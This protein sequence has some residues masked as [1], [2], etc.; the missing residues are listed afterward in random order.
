MV[1]TPDSTTPRSE[2]DGS[3]FGGNGN[4]A[5]YRL[6]LA[7]L[8][9]RQTKADAVLTSLGLLEDSNSEVPTS[10]LDEVPILEEALHSR[11]TLLQQQQKQEADLLKQ[12]QLAVTIQSPPLFTV[13]IL[14]EG[15]FGNPI[16]MG[17]I[18]PSYYC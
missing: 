18:G 16:R 13:P 4:H 15:V 9:A 11:D 8:T 7:L 17:Y 3:A 10:R 14:G 12:Q 1:I 2:L 6:L 5:R